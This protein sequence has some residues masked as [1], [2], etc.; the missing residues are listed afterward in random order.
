MGTLVVDFAHS[1]AS[2]SVPKIPNAFVS[3]RFQIEG[4]VERCK[5]N[6]NCKALV[7]IAFEITCNFL[8]RSR[9]FNANV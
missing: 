1:R 2:F 4:T 3:R 7:D 6:K 8:P 9:I 5:K